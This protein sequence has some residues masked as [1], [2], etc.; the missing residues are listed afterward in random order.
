MPAVD[1]R[2][3][4]FQVVGDVIELGV[5]GWIV[6]QAADGAALG[7]QRVHQHVGVLHQLADLFYR[8]LAGADNALQAG[9]FGG[10]EFGVVG[11]LGPVAWAEVISTK[12]S[13]S[14]PA[15]TVEVVESVCRKWIYCAADPHRDFDGVGATVGDDPN[16]RDVSDGDA[17]QRDRGAV[18]QSAGV[19]E[20]GAKSEFAGEQATGG[21]RHEEDDKNQNGHGRKDQ[22]ANSQL[23]PL[24]LFTA[25]HSNPLDE[26]DPTG[27]PH[28]L[29]NSRKGRGYPCSRQTRRGRDGWMGIAG[30]E[31]ATLFAI[32]S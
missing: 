5:E 28:R 29:E 7:V 16:L 12:L 4:L 6:N 11:W 18:F 32:E 20:V 2:G 15:W 30:G 8:L 9:S 10:A 19:I 1:G 27:L 14:T 22:C 13:P 25:R 3:Q 21:G 23:G 31:A 24:N 17:F 26:V